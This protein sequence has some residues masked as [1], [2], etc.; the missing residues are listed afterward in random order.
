MWEQETK[1]QT[2]LHSGGAAD[3]QHIF[4]NQN[5]Q[6]V[7]ACIYCKYCNVLGLREPG[8]QKGMESTNL[9]QL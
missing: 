2:L 6:P 4:E 1:R 7:L 3:G 8:E 5:A 9:P